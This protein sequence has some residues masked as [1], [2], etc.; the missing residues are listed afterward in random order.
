MVVRPFEFSV[1]RPDI[2][3]FPVVN[4]ICVVYVMVEPVSPFIIGQT[5]V[6]SVTVDASPSVK[7]LLRAYPHQATDTLAFLL[8]T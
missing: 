5:F 3:G 2:C 4:G 1:G 8:H 6:V 7:A